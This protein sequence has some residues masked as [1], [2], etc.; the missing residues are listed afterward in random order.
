MLQNI[1]K[2]ITYRMSITI[3]AIIALLCIES[4]YIN[5]IILIILQPLKEIHNDW[6]N[7]LLYNVINKAFITLDATQTELTQIKVNTTIEYM[8]TCEISIKNDILNNTI[9]ILTMHIIILTSST[10]ILY[11]LILFKMPSM[12]KHEQNIYIKEKINLLF[13]LFVAALLTHSL[14]AKLYMNIA[15]HNYKEFNYYEF[16]VDFDIHTYITQYIC[17]TYTHFCV[18][19]TLHNRKKI[20]IVLIII[21][22]LMLV[23]IQF[24]T[25]LEIIY[26][27]ILITVAYKAKIIKKIFNKKLMN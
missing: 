7:A 22:L 26:Y 20:Y 16:D 14:W 10:I 8:P 11:Q 18:L 24:I 23:T 15:F 21:A 27:A 13:I 5:E 6:N 12:Y 2:E 19:L 9:I 25:I 17:A 3:A 1:T 4:Q